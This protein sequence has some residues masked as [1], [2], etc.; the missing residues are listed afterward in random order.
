MKMTV[1]PGSRYACHVFLLQTQRAGA[2]I[3]SLIEARERRYRAEPAG[4]GCPV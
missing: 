2:N 4:V 1:L 3:H